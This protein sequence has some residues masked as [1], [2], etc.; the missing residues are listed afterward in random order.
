MNAC[1]HCIINW[2]AKTVYLCVNER[3]ILL[4][5][6]KHKQTLTKTFKR[7]KITYRILECWNRH[8]AGSTM[9]NPY[10]LPPMDPAASGSMTLFCAFFF[11]LPPE[12]FFCLLPI[13]YACALHC[14]IYRCRCWWRCW[15]RCRCR[16]VSESVG[17]RMWCHY[18]FLFWNRF[19]KTKPKNVF[20]SSKK[21]LLISYFIL[22]LGNSSG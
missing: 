15:W 19:E 21:L 18:N 20:F 1:V 10:L 12:D 2:V 13:M 11:F 9:I 8:R 22:S 3:L 16:W 7:Q 5:S 14:T 6:V 17:S 4:S